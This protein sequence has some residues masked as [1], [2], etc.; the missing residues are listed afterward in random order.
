MSECTH[1]LQMAVVTCCNCG[2]AFSMP[3]DIQRRYRETGESFFCP[4]GHK[5]HYTK[6]ELSKA[7]ERIAELERH[8]DY[9][10]ANRNS[11]RDRYWAA[12]NRERALKGWITRYRKKLG[13]D[14]V[15]RHS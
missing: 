12:L 10:R 8:Y 1:T 13:L 9:M 11:Y 7:K 2:I 4:N 5:Q 15:T 3:K 6:S 14:T